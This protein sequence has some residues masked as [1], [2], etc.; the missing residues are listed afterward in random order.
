MFGG[1]G[2]RRGPEQAET[3]S[4]GPASRAQVAERSASCAL[5]DASAPGGRPRRSAITGTSVGCARYPGE[6]VPGSNPVVLALEREEWAL[7]A[8]DV[9]ARCGWAYLI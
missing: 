7:P 5:P 1:L 8:R 2:V 6:G 3:G 9:L 4:L